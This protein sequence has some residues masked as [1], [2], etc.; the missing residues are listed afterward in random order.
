MVSAP[1]RIA[2]AELRVAVSER[3]ATLAAMPLHSIL[4]GLLAA[5]ALAGCRAPKTSASIYQ[6]DGPTVHY[7]KT[8][9]AGGPMRT[10][11]YR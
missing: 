1:Q 10:T 9:A 5:L 6:G 3:S 4:L 2:T 8:E 7:Y 11:H